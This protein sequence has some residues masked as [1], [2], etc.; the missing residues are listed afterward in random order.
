M[1]SIE[2]LSNIDI[3]N[4]NEDKPQQMLNRDKWIASLILSLLFIIISSPFIYRLLN[5]ITLIMGLSLSDENGAPNIL[6]LII[7]G[8]LFL[9]ITRF[10]MR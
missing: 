7:T 10:L 2:N 4:K 6:G 1:S 9:L 8:I 3:S 5:N